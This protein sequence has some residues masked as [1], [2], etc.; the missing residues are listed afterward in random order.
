MTA[1]TRKKRNRMFMTLVRSRR[2]DFIAILDSRFKSAGL[3]T[4]QTN[5]AD[6]FRVAMVEENGHRLIEKRPSDGGAELP[7]RHLAICW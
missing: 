2:G 7:V 6:V 4:H 3:L 1:T 5:P